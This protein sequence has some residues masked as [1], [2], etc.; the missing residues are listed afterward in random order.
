M[1][2]PRPLPEP[3]PDPWL[4]AFQKRARSYEETDEFLVGDGLVLN[5]PDLVAWYKR[6]FR[7]SAK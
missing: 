6:T 4:E 1:P 5:T 3:E 2:P 7:G